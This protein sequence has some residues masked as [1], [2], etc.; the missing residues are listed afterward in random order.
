MAPWGSLAV[1][2]QQIDDAVAVPVEKADGVAEERLA[3]APAGA[4]GGREQ[5]ATSVVL[6]DLDGYDVCS[7]FG[8]SAHREIEVTI[9]VE[10]SE[11]HR[12]RNEGIVGDRHRV[13]KDLS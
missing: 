2:H 6:Q 1:R 11:I 5:R 4:R 10:I 3:R 13:S 9:A 8:P 12:A 7:L